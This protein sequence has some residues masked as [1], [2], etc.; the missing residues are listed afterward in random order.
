MREGGRI[1]GTLRYKT[2]VTVM[3]RNQTFYS[4]AKFDCFK[5]FKVPKTSFFFCACLFVGFL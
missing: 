4:I 1:C 2:F 3:G 5:V